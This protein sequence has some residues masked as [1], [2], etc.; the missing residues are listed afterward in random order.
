MDIEKV[1]KELRSRN[2]DGWLFYDFR[3]RDEIAYKILGLDKNKIYSRKWYYYIPAHGEPRKL[4]HNI[5]SEVLDSLPGIKR[6][7]IQWQQQNTL[8]KEILYLAKRVAMQYS[9][10][11]AVPYI[12]LVD[13]GTIELIRSFG[14]EVVSSADLVQLFE[15][16]IPFASYQMHCEAG[17]I[18]HRIL[19]LCWKEIKKCIELGNI[20]NE[21]DLQQFVINEYEKYGIIYDDMLPI[22][23]INENTSNPHYELIKGRS[24]TIKKGDFLLIDLCGKLSKPNS[25]YYDVTWTAMVSDIIPE[26]YNVIFNIV[27]EARDLA[28]RFLEDR[29][30]EGK[31]VFGWEVDDAV[32]GYILR[33]GYG[34]Y[35]LH[36]TGHSIGESLHGNGANIDNLETKEERMLLP[37]NLFSIEPGIYLEEF[38]IRSEVNVYIDDNNKV[39][40]TGPKQEQIIKIIS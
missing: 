39:I 9:P 26:K 15:S 14:A 35:F 4:V 22:V 23:A 12:S 16:Y 34:N 25:V 17:K 20:I 11:N 5:E 37:G 33:K 28:I 18:I 7:Y 2:I 27:K 21:Y 8:L 32:R 13:A 6:T 29:F 19:D 36:R 31:E 40:V 1:Q 3:K 30:R 24:K 10:M 38:G